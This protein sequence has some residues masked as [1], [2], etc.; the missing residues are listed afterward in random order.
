[1]QEDKKPLDSGF[2]LELYALASRGA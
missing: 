1:M 2:L